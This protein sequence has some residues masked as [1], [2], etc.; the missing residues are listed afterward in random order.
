[1]FAPVRLNILS[2]LSGTASM[3][4]FLKKI[5]TALGLVRRP[6]AARSTKDRRSGDR[7]WPENPTPKREPRRKRE[8]RKK[9]RRN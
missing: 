2:I 1:M 9:G 7:R 3:P 8:R 5:L 4:A 6:P